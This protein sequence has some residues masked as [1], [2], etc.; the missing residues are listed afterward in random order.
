M[1]SENTETLLTSYAKVA[2]P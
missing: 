2:V 1:V